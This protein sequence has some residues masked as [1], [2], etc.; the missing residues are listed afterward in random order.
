MAFPKTIQL[1]SR[2][3]LQL[4]V[5]AALVLGGASPAVAAE[6]PHGVASGDVT[7]VGAILWTRVDGPAEIFA[8]V[9]SDAQF[10]SLVSSELF[11]VDSSND[12]T[13]K[14]DLSGLEAS[15]TYW[16]R[17]VAQTSENEESPVGQFR[18]AP[19]PNEQAGFRFLFSG[20]SDAFFA[21]L[22][23]FDFAAGEEAD[24]AI[25]AGDT[26]YADREFNGIGPA[27]TL[28]EYRAKYKQMR[29]D[30]SVADFLASTA[31]WTAWDDH[32]VANDYDGGE[33]EPSISP[34]QIRDAYQSFFEYM[35]IRHQN[36]AGDE[37][38]IYRRFRYGQ[39]AEFFILDGRQYRSADASRRCA[40]DGFLDTLLSGATLDCLDAIKDPSRTMLGPEQRAWL[41]DGLIGSDARY[42]FVV[43]NTPLTYFLGAIPY[44]RWEGYESEL[45]WLFETIDL[46]RIEGVV[47]LTSDF[48]LNALN[49]DVG[50]FYRRSRSEYALDNGVR[51]IEAIVGP[52]ATE[53]FGQAVSS[54]GGI[55]APIIGTAPSF[56]VEA[57]TNQV[58]Q[59][60]ELS[61]LEPNRYAYLV[62][63]VTE[64]GDLNLTYRG[65]DPDDR[66]PLE[67]QTLFHASNPGEQPP[68]PLPCILPTFAMSGGLVFAFRFAHRR[69]KNRAWDRD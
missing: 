57:A 28:D 23:L 3:P 16:F 33:P 25:W 34:L 63:E 18:T 7:S 47:F 17:F 22:A 66:N 14:W 69:A 30:K 4:S 44:D 62:V 55:A 21:P 39:W 41:A 8:E 6:F 52:I 29:D 40:D 32:E 46:N 36:V 5:C 65:I 38:R 2:V 60:N 67:A 51:S 48:H 11:S 24:F 54:V 43:N 42:K 49:P 45:Q 9:S 64:N 56:L 27:V 58:T 13:L 26:I 31:V 12:F 35:P 15:T 10:T 19:D 68:D 59:L 20:D 53:T 1:P 61:F 37:R 50:S